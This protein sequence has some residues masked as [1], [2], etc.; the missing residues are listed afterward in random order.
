MKIKEKLKKIVMGAFACITMIGVMSPSSVAAASTKSY[1]MIPLYNR[2]YQEI[3]TS[4]LAE[5]DTNA[6]RYVDGYTQL[7]NV[8]SVLLPQ[9]E[10]DILEI[11]DIN[12]PDDALNSE[13]LE[14]SLS[15]GGSYLEFPGVDAVGTVSSRDYDQAQSIADAITKNLN[16]AI[17]IVYTHGE[18]KM[19]RTDATFLNILRDLTNAAY[20]NGGVSIDGVAF[21]FGAAA[22]LNGEAKKEYE[23]KYLSNLNS[24]FKKGS[25]LEDFVVITYEGSDTPILLQYRFPKGYATGQALESQVTDEQRAEIND[26]ITW[27]GIGFFVLYGAANGVY[28]G[29]ETFKDNSDVSNAIY[30]FFYDIIT[31]VSSVFGIE[32]AETLMLNRGREGTYLLGTMPVNWFSLGSVLFWLAQIIAIVI[33]FG[34]I[35][36]SILKRNAS[37]IS[38]SIRASMKED[39]V[40]IAITIILLVLFLPL[41]YILMQTNYMI[42]ESFATL[43]GGDSLASVGAAAGLLQ[44]LIALLISLIVVAV[45][46]VQ[47]FIRQ[48][49]L[50]ILYIVSP[51]AISSIAF[52]GRKSSLFDSWFKELIAN[53][54]LQSI[55]AGIL[56]VFIILSRHASFNLF[57]SIMMMA[58]FI[59]LNKWFK[60]QVVGLSGHGADPVVEQA[61]QTVAATV[62]MGAITAAKGV[63]TAID[64]AKNGGADNASTGVSSSAAASMD[65]ARTEQQIATGEMKVA[66]GNSTSLDGPQKDGGLWQKITGKNNGQKEPKPTTPL[67]R[68]ATTLGKEALRTGAVIAAG[69]V[70]SELDTNVGRSLQHEAIE[71]GL[72]AHK[73]GFKSVGGYKFDEE[74]HDQSASL[75]KD[76]GLVDLPSK[77]TNEDIEESIL[78]VEEDEDKNS[79]F[80]GYKDRLNDYSDN[81]KVKEAFNVNKYTYLSPDGKVVNNREEAGLNNGL[82]LRFMEVKPAY[83]KQF[84]DQTGKGENSATVV[85]TDKV[86]QASSLLNTYTDEK[87]KQHIGFVYTA[88]DNDLA[89]SNPYIQTYNASDIQ[90]KIDNVSKKV[91]GYKDSFWGGGLKSEDEFRD[92]SVDEQHEYLSNVNVYDNEFKPE[93]VDP[94]SDYYNEAYQNEYNN[95][96]EY[97]EDYKSRREAMIPPSWQSN[98]E[99]AAKQYEADKAVRDK[100]IM[101]NYYS[102]R[103]VE[104]PEP[105][106]VNSI[107]TNKH[108]KKLT[109]KEISTSN[110]Y[111]AYSRFKKIQKQQ[112]G[113]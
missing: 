25:T 83:A 95:R 85:N 98:M 46:N 10:E 14:S 42:V 64:A 109:Y 96:V 113:K 33:L 62:G 70:A 5:Q 78:D 101:D 110:N 11:T 92:L 47:Y 89:K 29:S 104:K 16:Q 65:K 61:K 15:A 108:D 103:G 59:P 73:N 20:T 32:S 82:P 27:K 79:H 69:A 72:G 80:E 87:G 48:V 54:F 86:R 76:E 34:S 30:N 22:A 28:Y 77:K 60:N 97:L 44:G 105:K 94:H 1:V 63:H 17:D 23:S 31:G 88:N 93:Y 71:W 45:L 3:I 74:D 56:A 7:E 35:I 68:F 19:E 107:V 100:E 52:S 2:G 12:K 99:E 81:F 55:N 13:T 57:T 50:L 8:S 67:G 43:V 40:N 102:E 36:K 39:I 90:N 53:L 75:I 6:N 41:L 49:T 66:E 4:V 37:T 51:I 58:A 21:H 9:K 84:M 26:Y 106:P 111:Q 38:P 18:S 91:E 112:E 24:N